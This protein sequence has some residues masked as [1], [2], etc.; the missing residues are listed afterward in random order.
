M[1]LNTYIHSILDKYNK[2]LDKYSP[3]LNF[4]GTSDREEHFKKI[5]E[6]IKKEF[7]IEDTF[8]IVETDFDYY[9]QKPIRH[10]TFNNFNIDYIHA[11]YNSRVDVFIIDVYTLKPVYLG[12]NCKIIKTFDKDVSLLEVLKIKNE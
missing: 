9:K 12:M 2:E 11:G 5:K 7:D 6:T 10:I 8:L 1:K 4:D 3:T